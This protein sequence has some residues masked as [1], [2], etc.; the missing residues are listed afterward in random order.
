MNTEKNIPAETQENL[1]PEPQVTVPTPPAEVPPMP[2]VGSESRLS[3][4][5][6]AVILL[7]VL[8]LAGG[9]VF[10]ISNQINKSANPPSQPTVT[11]EPSVTSTAAG[12]KLSS[13]DDP[14]ILETELKD[15]NLDDLN[16]D[17]AELNQ[18]LTNL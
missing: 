4:L 2:P 8:I 10:F 16:Q 6:V 1:S 9:A 5:R 17:E 14:E 13:S 12:L 7:A 15:V 18:E 11:A 3:T